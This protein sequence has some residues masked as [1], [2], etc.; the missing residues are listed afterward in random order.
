MAEETITRRTVGNGAD[1]SLHTGGTE[2]P[3]HG[4]AQRF[5]FMGMAQVS[6]FLGGDTDIPVCA[7]PV[8]SV[9]YL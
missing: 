1:V 9:C 6:L 2:I 4:V 8:S 5:P 7:S 3:L